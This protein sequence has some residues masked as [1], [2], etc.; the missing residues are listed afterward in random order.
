MYINQRRVIACYLSNKLDFWYLY[1]VIHYPITNFNLQEFF[2]FFKKFL[3]LI[4]TIHTTYSQWEGNLTLH[5]EVH[6]SIVVAD[7]ILSVLILRDRLQ[8]R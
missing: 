8:G 6:E 3:V 2:N 4:F 7:S 5:W 1:F